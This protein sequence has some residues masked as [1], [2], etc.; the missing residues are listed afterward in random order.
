MRWL[1]SWVLSAVSLLIVAHVVP[2]I[3]VNGLVAALIAAVVIGLINAT[4]GLLLKIISLPIIIVSFGIFWFIINAA[5]LKLASLL[6]PGFKVRGFV[7][8][9]LGSILLSVL[10]M[11]LH[12][13]LLPKR[14]RSN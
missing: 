2:G 12:W 8:A 3:Y 1:L 14:K 7:A 4:L 6:V 5:M 9:L 13:L 11:V 10:N